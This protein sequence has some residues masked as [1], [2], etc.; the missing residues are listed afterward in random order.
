[1]AKPSTVFTWATSAENDGISGQPNTRQ[2]PTA[3]SAKGFAYREKPPRN[4]L[5]WALNLIGQWCVWLDGL[6][7]EALTWTAAHVFG[8]GIDVTGGI[9]ADSVAGDSVATLEAD[10]RHGMRGEVVS[11]AAARVSNCTR[12]P[13]ANYSDDANGFTVYSLPVQEG[14]TLQSVVQRVLPTASATVTID[15]YKHHF[16]TDTETLIG[17]DTSST[18]GLA[19]LLQVDCGDL[20]IQA[21][22]SYYAVWNASAASQ[23]DYGLTVWT[24]RVAP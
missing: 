19:Q 3:K 10:V 4:W 8:A 20:V 14:Q 6:T 13:K 17:S 21:S 16:V 5:N 2:P 22:Y 18:S 23:Y 12:V 1:M 15:V 7:D 9:T 11:A 24:T